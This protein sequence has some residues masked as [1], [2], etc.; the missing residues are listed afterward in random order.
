MQHA[1]HWIGLSWVTIATLHLHLHLTELAKLQKTPV[2]ATHK[3]K[4]PTMD[5]E[6]ARKESRRVWI[7][8]IADRGIPMS[9]G[10]HF[11]RR[12]VLW[13]RTEFPGTGS[14]RVTPD[15]FSV[16]QKARI[17]IL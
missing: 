4:F 11:H 6:R 8:Q 10:K 17:A 12:F 1:F 7:C 13:D 9:A 2:D 5:R 3:T 15:K 14:E 16:L